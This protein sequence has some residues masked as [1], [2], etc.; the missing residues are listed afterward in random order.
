MPS[1]MP[2]SWEELDSGLDTPS[3]SEADPE[4]EPETELESPDEPDTEDEL[5]DATLWRQEQGG[6]V[7]E[8]DARVAGA[9][10]E[11]NKAIAQNNEVEAAYSETQRKL[12]QQR[13]AGQA[14]LAA[15]E[16]KHG[17]HLRKLD[18]YRSEQ[19]AAQA[20]EL[21]LR[22]VSAKLEKARAVLELATEALTLQ[23]DGATAQQLAER[24][25]GNDDWREVESALQERRADAERAVRRLT[26]ERRVAAAEAERRAKRLL[27]KAAALGEV[28][29]AALPYLARQASVEFEEASLQRSLRERG[30]DAA[31]AK[32]CVKQAM[33]DLERISLEIMHNQSEA[34]EGAEGPGGRAGTGAET[35]AAAAQRQEQAPSTTSPSSRLR[36]A[37]AF[38]RRRS[39]SST[40][41]AMSSRSVESP[42]SG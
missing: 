26:R 29:S 12:Q 3:E 11:L 6:D 25:A 15:L 10:N 16:K 18:R 5:E 4:T 13:E 22:E 35:V 23:R 14:S 1:A 8:L 42:K 19:S 9:F 17:R 7:E 40:E 20:A 2:R 24:R 36:R 31:R 38:P 39:S 27:D 30:E 41:Q 21:A 33:G 37:D 28:A 34:V 32:A